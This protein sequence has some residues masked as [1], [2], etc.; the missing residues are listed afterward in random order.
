MHQGEIRER[1]SEIE[2]TV[3]EF[4]KQEERRAIKH[5]MIDGQKWVR[6]FELP[7]PDRGVVHIKIVNEIVVE[8]EQQKKIDE[9]KAQCNQKCLDIR[10]QAQLMVV[11]VGYKRG[12]C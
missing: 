6:A 1:V 12:C 7:L 2:Q 8:A 5:P 10:P 3:D 11:V 4:V 9:S